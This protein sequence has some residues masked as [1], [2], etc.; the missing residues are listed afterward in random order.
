MES[1][2]EE[3]SHQ[4]YFLIEISAG[5]INNCFSAMVRK[6]SNT[7]HLEV[8]SGVV[9]IQ[10]LQNDIV[11]TAAQELP[12]GVKDSWLFILVVVRSCSIGFR[13]HE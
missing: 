3:W 7:H 2:C 13:N 6:D 11:S 12:S 5:K 8:I 4:V 10:L 1:N 9:S